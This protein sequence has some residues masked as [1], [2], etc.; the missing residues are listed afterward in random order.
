MSLRPSLFRSRSL[1]S[2]KDT[3]SSS[4]QRNNERMVQGSTVRN[5]A[6]TNHGKNLYS[7]IIDFGFQ[8][9][10]YVGNYFR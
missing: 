7:R 6:S 5:Y 4:H 10:G 3:H 2:I 1:K 9:N 8:S